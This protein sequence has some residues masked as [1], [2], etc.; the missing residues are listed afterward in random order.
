MTAETETFRI[1]DGYDRRKRTV[2]VRRINNEEIAALK[3]GSR[4][5][6]ISNNGMLRRAK[7][8]S[9]KRWKTKPDIEVHAKYGM[10]EFGILTIDRIIK[11]VEE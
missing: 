8:T 7:V 3:S 1:A 9:V 4:I 10:Y 5:C 6:F 11:E 2:L